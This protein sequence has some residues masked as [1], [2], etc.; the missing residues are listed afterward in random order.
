M[1][2]IA[3]TRGE[4]IPIIPRP[5]NIRTIQNGVVSYDLVAR[6]ISIPRN[7]SPKR[8][9]IYKLF[10]SVSL[11]M[12]YFFSSRSVLMYKVYTL[13]ERYKVMYHTDMTFDKQL[14]IFAR[15][16]STLFARIALFIVFFWFGI[17]KIINVSPANPLVSALLEQTLPF[18]T[19]NQFIIAFGIYEMIIG[20]IFLKKGW[21]RFAI[22]LLVPHMITTV[23]PL[24]LL[25]NVSWTSPLVPTLEGQYM[26]KN[27]LIIAVAMI[28]GSKL[29]PLP[30]EK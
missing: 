26:I 7:E 2:H 11:T 17:L 27:V 18:I 28:L 10:Q 23:L 3:I 22:L 1:T 12:L 8:I 13:A 5:A 29:T 6:I 19:F 16:N 30:E 21:E 25:P 4:S 15:R 14:I 20:L 24:F 9:L